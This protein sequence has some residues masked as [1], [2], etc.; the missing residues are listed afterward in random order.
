MQGVRTVGHVP[1][2]QQAAALPWL[3]PAGPALVALTDAAPPLSFLAADPAVLL[4]ALRYARPSP[5]VDDCLDPDVL[6]QPILLDAAAA[7]LDAR[8]PGWSDPTD[9]PTA[10]LLGACRR[11]ASFARMIASRSDLCPPAAAHAAGLLVPVGWLAVAA[12]DPAA[13]EGC[14]TTADFATDPHAAQ[15]RCW[16]LS[17]DAI[18]RRLA[19][20]WRLPQWLSAVIAN[21]HHEVDDAAKLGADR[22]LVSVVRAAV[23]SAERT[24]RRLG[25][26]GLSPTADVADLIPPANSTPAVGE[27]PGTAAVPANAD[28]RTIALLPQLLR[29]AAR[30]RRSL[31]PATADADLDRLHQILAETRSA[32]A[33][34][35]RDAKL[36][37]LAELAAGAGH[38]INNPLAVISGNAQLLR[39][40]ECDPDR[41]QRL[42]AIVRQ[43]RR[44]AEI[45]H[46]LRQFARPPRPTPAPVPV[47]D[48]VAAAVA[49]YEPHAKLKGV[50]LTAAPADWRMVV[51]ADAGQV[52]RALGHLIRNAVE[53]TPTSGTVRVSVRSTAG[54]VDLTVEDTG[55]GPAE[56]AVPH[57]FDPFFSGRSAGRGRGMGL[58]T[59]W[60]L[61]TQNGG[62]IRFDR[63]PGGPTRFT[64]TLP[65]APARPEAVPERRSA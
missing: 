29:A 38:E 33:D 63:P 64:L 2:G 39:G 65:L 61:A 21:V 15:R 26:L 31:R 51:V 1:V 13:V 4:L 10:E 32:F 30:G 27:P 34:S 60:R 6:E 25:L 18:V 5:T 47:A 46:D 57:L 40:R 45:L 52:R 42:D 55:G 35:V 22:G 11:I 36:S 8:S 23:A 3:G 16:G 12:A 54:T 59:A 48:L 62:D 14:R 19:A 43:A 17:H 53:A 41:Q 50:E 7:H 37:G 9:E 20:R 49:E 58:P 28:P 44:I 24:G 56:D